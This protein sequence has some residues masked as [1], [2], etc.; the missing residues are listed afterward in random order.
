M[1][2]AHLTNSISRSEASTPKDSSP[3]GNGNITSYKFVCPRRGSVTE[4]T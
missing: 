2:L 4:A 3:G 1:S